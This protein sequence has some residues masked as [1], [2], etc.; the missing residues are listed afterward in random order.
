M[1]RNAQ[2]TMGGSSASGST[3][4]A[5]AYQ[6]QS[7]IKNPFSS[8]N[9]SR[10]PIAAAA[11]EWASKSSQ[12]VA[13]FEAPPSYNSSVGTN[14][15]RQWDQTFVDNSRSSNVKNPVGNDPNNPFQ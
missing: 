6:P 3:T 13:N 2:Q 8:I 15:N 10:D 11:A 12:S 9:I 4:P 5:G 7:S 1:A 14:Q